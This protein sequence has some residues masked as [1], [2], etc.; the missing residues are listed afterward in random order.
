MELTCLGSSSKGN[1]YILEGKS[2][3]I[4]LESG[5]KFEE[6]K[7]ALDFKFDDV[8]GCLVTHEHK[9][10]LKYVDAVCKNA[11][12]TFGSAG[13]LEGIISNYVNVIKSK[14]VIN[15]GEFK[16]MAFDSVH[17]VREPLNFLIESVE[18]KERLLFLTDTAYCRYTFKN[19]DYLMI[20]ANYRENIL[21]KSV[22]DGVY[23]ASLADRIRNNHMEL[24]TTCDIVK[25]TG[26]KKVILIHTSDQNSNSNEFRNKVIEVT[27]HSNVFVASKGFTKKLGG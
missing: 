9:D 15:I 16:I 18:T 25:R 20:E 6:V 3:K 21:C 8:V 1:C 19:I 26:A 24:S 4:I 13:T 27:G 2:S 22:D 23:P 10:H 5:V 7:Q 11:I 17:D 12:A 14:E